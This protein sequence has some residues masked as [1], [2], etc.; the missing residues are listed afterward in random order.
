ME[1][2]SINVAYWHGT[3]LNGM[4]INHNTVFEYSK[5]KMNEII[6]GSLENDYQVM[7]KRNGHVLIIW[8][9]NKYFKQR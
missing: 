1:I 5:E 8:I 2:K 7:L 3:K 6:D 9:D 4:N